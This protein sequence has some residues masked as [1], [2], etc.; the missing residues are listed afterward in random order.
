MHKATTTTDAQKILVSI[1]IQSNGF[2]SRV[3]LR[4]EGK[5]GEVGYGGQHEQPWRSFSR[6][7]YTCTN[8]VRPL[9][10]INR[11]VSHCPLDLW[12]RELTEADQVQCPP[13]APRHAR[14]PPRER[15]S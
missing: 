4:A 9:G 11:T 1:F 12:H 13:P 8:S 7:E 10:S 3:W 15:F 2:V 14:S 6:V 5:I